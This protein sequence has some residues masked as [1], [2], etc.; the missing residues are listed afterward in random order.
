[1]RITSF[2]I[3]NQL[4]RSL[5]R[6]MEKMSGLYN[7]LSSGK[8]MDKPSDDVIGTM[9]A[10]DYKLSI[11]GNGQYRRNADEAVAHLDFT[12]KV[13]GSVSN[14]LTRIK[15]LA[16]QGVNG[17]LNAEDRAA[18]AKEVAQLRDHLLNL[19]NSKLRDRY[20]FSGFR[21]D[22]ESF[23]PV[24]FDYQGDTGIINVLIDREAVMPINVLG[25]NLF[26][27]ALAA[28]DV[29]RLEDGKY[30]HYIPGAGTTINVE[31]RDTDNTTVLDSFSFSNFIQMTDILSSALGNNNLLRI[32]ALLRPLDNSLE[33]V[34]NVQADV[35]A[36]LNRLDDQMN[37]LDDSTYNLKALLSNTEDVDIAETTSDIS[38]TETALQALRQSSA[39][40]LSQSLLDFIR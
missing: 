18:I 13:T 16:L 2:M 14:A 25:T 34:I 4:T 28:E 10:M 40:I 1:M 32:K 27:Y 8:K 38:K 12:E 30:I 24:T 22:I 6:N 3:F 23:N 5:Q 36:R 11:N 31:I 29:L 35:G 15:E 37:R 7:Q 21:T 39:Q 33:Q 26:S 17:T 9:R 19:S 20:V